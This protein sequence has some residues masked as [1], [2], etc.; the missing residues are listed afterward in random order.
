M[1][2]ESG[3]LVIRSATESDAEKLTTWWNDGAV[4]AHAGFPKG[5]DTSVETVREQIARNLTS[6]GQ[7][8]ALE[9]DSHPIGECSYWVKDS[10]AEI[11]IKI[12]EASWQDQGLGTQYLKLLIGYLFGEEGSDQDQPIEKIVLDTN[13]KNLRAQHVYEKLGFRKVCVHE[14]ASQ[15]QLGAWQSSVDYELYKISY[16]LTS[17]RS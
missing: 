4:M 7:R 1:R 5:L 2:I 11:G 17:L 6:R 15:D 8:C 13:L 3:N 10:T 12:C 14:N 9:I 16:N